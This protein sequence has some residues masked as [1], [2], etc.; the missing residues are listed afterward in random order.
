MTKQRK[1][2]MPATTIDPKVQVKS[3]SGIVKKAVSAV[4]K[5]KRPSGKIIAKVEVEE[6]GGGDGGKY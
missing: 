6:G 3:D 2:K 1:D 4:K 5:K